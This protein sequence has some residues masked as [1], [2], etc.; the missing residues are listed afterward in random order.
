MKINS[1]HS[2]FVLSLVLIL[3][4]CGEKEPQ[5]QAPRVMPYP[6]VKVENQT[7]TSYN[8]FPTRIEGEVNSDVRPKVSGYIKNVLVDEGDVVK[9]GQLLFKLETAALSQDAEASKANV[10]AAQVEVDKLKP[11]VEKNIISKVQLETAKAR[12]AQAKSAYNGVA[13]N[14]NYANVKS[15]VN[16]VVGSINYRK[17]ALVSAQDPLPITNVSSIDNVFAYFSMNEKQFIDFIAEAE[18]ETYQDKIAN[19]PKVKLKLA[20]NAFYE[21]EGTIETITGD[22]NQQTGTITFRAKFSN[23]SGVLRNGSSGTVLVPNTFKN[24][25]VVPAE[26]TFE[27]QGKYYVYGVQGDSLV[28]RPIAIKATANRLYIV[29]SGLEKGETILAKGINKLGPGSKIKPMPISMDSIVKSF[30]TVFK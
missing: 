30:N 22:I 9:Q 6:V 14:I 11:L 3:S 21:Q 5:Q 28:T 19:F 13:A 16:G 17:G 23:A 15:P 20:N 25:L 18:G 7:I 8:S 4:S 29:E 24:A 27:R 26:S 10:N 12:L 2:L 1:I